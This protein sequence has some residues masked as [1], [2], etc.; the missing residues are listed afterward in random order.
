MFEFFKRLVSPAKAKKNDVVFWVDLPEIPNPPHPDRRA[1]QCRVA[2]EPESTASTRSVADSAVSA[3]SIPGIVGQPPTGQSSRKPRLSPRRKHPAAMANRRGE[4]SPIAFH[5]ERLLAMRIEHLKLCPS[6]R[7]EQLAA[8]GIQTAGDLI[9]GDPKRIAETFRN[10]ARA[11]RA[12]RRYRAA[13]KLALSVESMMPRDALLLVAIHRRSVASLSRESAA[14][15]HRD[16]ERFSMSSRGSKMIGRRGVPSLRRVKAWVA[17]CREMAAA[18]AAP[19]ELA[20][21][22]A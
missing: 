1:V 2:N 7:C 20:R 4:K 19:P 13:I 5:R 9:Y 11:E 22:V 8:I 17:T 10:P 3:M 12:I 16:L 18:A 6:E 14:Q 21:Q 15:L